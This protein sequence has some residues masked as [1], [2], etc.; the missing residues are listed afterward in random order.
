MWRASGK[1]SGEGMREGGGVSD[2]VKRCLGVC[3]MGET[4]HYALIMHLAF[5]MA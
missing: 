4:A 3:G 2:G 5:Q 1:G